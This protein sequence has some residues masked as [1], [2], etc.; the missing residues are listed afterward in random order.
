MENQE[1]EWVG[2]MLDQEAKKLRAKADL[3]ENGALF[4]DIN[5]SNVILAEIFRDSAKY[6]DSKKRI[7]TNQ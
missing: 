3:L 1:L 6:M 7:A 5:K 4:E 2:R